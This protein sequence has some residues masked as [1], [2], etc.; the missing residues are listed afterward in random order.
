MGIYVS[1]PETEKHSSDESARG[2]R[3]G[4]SCMQ[5]WRKSQ[6]VSVWHNVLYEQ[7]C[8]VRV[9]FCHMCSN[10]VDKTLKMSL[11]RL[12]FLEWTCQHLCRMIIKITCIVKFI[13]M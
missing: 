2:L 6:E 12:T 8:S 7:M 13:K 4:S 5:G 9:F 3:C 1:K 10:R 11:N